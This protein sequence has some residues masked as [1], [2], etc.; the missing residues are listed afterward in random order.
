VLDLHHEVHHGATFAAAEAVEGAMPRADVERRRLLVVKRAQ[1]LERIRT[2]PAQ[3]NVLA[4]DLVD[5]VAL[6][7]L[8]DVLVPDPSS[9]NRPV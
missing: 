7:D 5:P 3:R 4:D 6:A 9:H 2:S 1:P 8:S